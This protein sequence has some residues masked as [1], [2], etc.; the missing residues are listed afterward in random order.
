[1]K[2][3]LYS[4]LI[5]A[6]MACSNKTSE[7]A[8]QLKTE[9]FKL[10]DEIMPVSMELEGFREKIIKKSETLDSTAKQDALAISKELDETYN[11]M[12]TWMT[13]LGDVI[14]MKDSDEKIKTLQDLKTEGNKI[15]EK[16]LNAKKKAEDFLK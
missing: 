15:K 7:E 3:L 16:T 2:T 8:A 4:L 13:K 14:D 6:T 9:T 11:D 12:E 10:H 5:L 1:M